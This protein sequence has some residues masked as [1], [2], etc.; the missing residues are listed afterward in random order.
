MTELV[1]AS[2]SRIR[3]DLLR[4]AGLDIR[5]VPSTLDERAVEAPLLESGAEPA[6]IATIL[7][8]A[9]ATDVSGNNPGVLVIGAD[10]VL[11][12]DGERLTKADDMEGARR[13]LLKLAGR[14]HALHSAVALIR[15]GQTVWNTVST[16]YLTM[17]P[18]SP[19]FVGRYLAKI[20][21]S[22][23]SSV[24]CY[25]LEGVGVQLFEKIEGDYFTILGLPLLPLLGELRRLGEI[26]A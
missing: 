9:K 10:Q 26:D 7:A 5:V 18:F 11:D 14:Q 4:N 16:A 20:G 13:Q 6:D 12:I 23:L 3:A 17:R 19:E 2:G 21:D 25:Q 24:G 8:D 15:D 1:L 22:A